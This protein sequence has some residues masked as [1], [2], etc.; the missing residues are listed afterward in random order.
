MLASNSQRTVS[1]VRPTALPDPDEPLKFAGPDTVVRHALVAGAQMEFGTKGDPNSLKVEDL[2]H[3][4]F[5][6]EYLARDDR[7]P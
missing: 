2:P 5:T 4:Q 7:Q 1:D 3:V 6:D